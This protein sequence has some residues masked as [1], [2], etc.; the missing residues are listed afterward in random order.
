MLAKTAARFEQE[1][2]DGLALEQ[3][4]RERIDER[5]VT[6]E[7]KHRIDERGVVGY[8]R[9]K[10]A[11]ERDAA[12]IAGRQPQI[13]ARFEKRGRRIRIAQARHLR[14]AQRLCDRRFCKQLLIARDAEER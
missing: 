7:A 9:A 14:I 6:I 2:I 12:R 8:L 11:R 10:L 1:L 13:H 5:L 4:R 3:R